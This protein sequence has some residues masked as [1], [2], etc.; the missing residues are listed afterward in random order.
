MERRQPDGVERS[1]EQ[2]VAMIL[3]AGYDGISIS[4][5][6]PEL[7]RRAASLISPYRKVIEAQCFPKTVDDLKP[8]LELAE[9][10]GV[11][12]LDVQADVRPRRIADCLPLIEGWRRL[13]EQ[14]DFP[15]YL[16]THRDR[17]TTDLYF[18]LD[19]LDC[20]PDL[21]LLAD[22]SHIM[23]GREFSVPIS[24]ENQ[25]YM[26]KI[27][28]SSWAFH[29]RVASREQVQVEISFP[30]HRQ[31]LEIFL[32]WWDYGFR[33]WS[34]RAGPD[35]S[36]AFVCELGPRPYAIVDRDG[37]DTTDRWEEALLLK[38]A[39]EALWN[40]SGAGKAPSHTV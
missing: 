30:V 11:H 14:V 23:V 7:A 32:G 37:N 39:V 31:W 15:V 21:K 17:L 20:V 2:N 29:G 3:A 22:L 34:R 12:H 4:I 19:L 24:P 8:A 28:D 6:D 1:L 33:S 13:W 16:E 38:R 40:N 25:I 18:T 26:R 36:L 10:L 5:S 35:D 9:K 27:I